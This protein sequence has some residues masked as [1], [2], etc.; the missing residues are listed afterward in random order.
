[1]PFPDYF[2]QYYTLE[3][4]LTCSKARESTVKQ[5]IFSHKPLR[6]VEQE[7]TFRLIITGRANLLCIKPQYIRFYQSHICSLSLSVFFVWRSHLCLLSL[8]LAM[9]FPWFRYLHK[10][11]EWSPRRLLPPPLIV[12][13]MFEFLHVGALWIDQ[14]Y[15]FTDQ[16]FSTISLIY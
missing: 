6:V 11:E 8:N 4:L 16:S 2:V 10:S 3:K 1:M 15:S 12:H 14:T 5:L 9:C 7:N 13:H